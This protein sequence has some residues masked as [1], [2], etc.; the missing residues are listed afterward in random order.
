MNFAIKYKYEKII[1]FNVILLFLLNFNNLISKT[2]LTTHGKL[3]LDLTL[4]S[5]TLSLKVSTFFPISNSGIRATT[6]GL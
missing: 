5:F 2:F 6:A 3:L 4:V 1:L